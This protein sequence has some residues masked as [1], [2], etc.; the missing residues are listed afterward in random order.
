MPNQKVK[1]SDTEFFTRKKMITYSLVTVIFIVFIVL[2]SKFVLDIDFQ[3]M[4]NSLSASR[5]N[6]NFFL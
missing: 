4:F 1:I 5:H 2:V 3:G 6:S